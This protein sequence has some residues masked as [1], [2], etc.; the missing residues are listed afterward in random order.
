MT[1]LALSLSTLGL[2]DLDAANRAWSDLSS[3]LD[4][5]L[6]D[7]KRDPTSV[8]GQRAGGQ[9]QQFPGSVLF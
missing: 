3:D 8:D 1:E 9:D 2:K 5:S 6:V 4:S 7:L